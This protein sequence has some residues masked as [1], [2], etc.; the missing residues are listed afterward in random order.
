MSLAECLATQR[1]RGVPNKVASELI[2]HETFFFIFVGSSCCQ[3]PLITTEED[4]D[5]TQE[6]RRLDAGAAAEAAAFL[7]EPV[8]IF[9]GEQRVPLKAFL[10]V[11]KHL[12]SL[13]Y[14]FQCLSTF[15]IYSIGPVSDGFTI[16][17]TNI[18]V[19]CWFFFFCFACSS[20]TNK[21]LSNFFHLF[22]FQPNVNRRLPLTDFQSRNSRRLL[23]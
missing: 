14:F 5:E 15:P 21:S 1:G 20:S 16:N 6:V 2:F 10:V 12:S 11:V 17:K 18:S 8:G 19:S 7:S 23:G 13:S 4:E 22:P 9:A 3:L